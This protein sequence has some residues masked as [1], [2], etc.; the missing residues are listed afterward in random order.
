MREK[1]PYR[2]PYYLELQTLKER[3]KIAYITP[4][5]WIYLLLPGDPI[6]LCNPR[7]WKP[8]VSV[9]LQAIKLTPVNLISKETLDLFY[10]LS[11][12]IS[13][14][15]YLEAAYQEPFSP[16]DFVNVLTLQLVPTPEKAYECIIDGI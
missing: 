14:I 7:T 15:E 1:F 10:P 6:E 9:G 3:T 11:D 2:L 8:Y 5:N 16:Y 13:V 4:V 12:H